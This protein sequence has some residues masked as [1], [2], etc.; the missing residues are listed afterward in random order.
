MTEEIKII[1]S[2]ENKEPIKF[3]VYEKLGT[4]IYP[5]K[6]GVDFKELVKNKAIHI[7]AG[8]KIVAWSHFHGYSVFEVKDIGDAFQIESGN[9]CGCLEFD[10]EDGHWI[11][12]GWYNK[13]ALDKVNFEK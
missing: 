12:I 1:E 7:Q 5:Y 10:E 9:L 4:P 13:K 2:N 8:D 11:C 6:E 3:K